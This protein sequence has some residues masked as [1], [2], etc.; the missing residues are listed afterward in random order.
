M[1]GVQTCAL[2]ICYDRDLIVTHNMTADNLLHAKKM[3]GIPVPSQIKS[4]I[5]N[6]GTFDANDPS[7]LHQ[8]DEAPKGWG[9]VEGSLE[10]RNQQPGPQSLGVISLGGFPAKPAV[11]T[12]LEKANASTYLH[13]LGHFFLETYTHIAD[14][15]NVP[16]KI[17]KDMQTILDGFGVKDVATWRAM[18]LEERRPL[19]EQ[20]AKSYEAYLMEGKAPTIAQ[21]PMFARFSAWLTKVYTSLQA[22]GVKL[23]PEVRGVMD[24]MTGSEKAIAEA[25]QVRGMEALF[26]VKPEGMTDEAYE[27]YQALGHDATGAAVASLQQRSLRDM[28]WL[29]N[30]KGRAVRSLQRQ[31]RAERVKIR[32]EVEAAVSEVP[33]YRAEDLLAKGIFNGEKVDT[34]KT[35]LDTEA[36]AEMYGGAGADGKSD[37]YALLDWKPLGKLAGPD[38]IHP[39]MAAHM[40]GFESGDALVKALLE[41]EPRKEMV[42]AMVDKR[43]LEEHGELIDP[44]SIERAAEAAIHNDMRTRVLATELTALAK[45]T[46][47]ARLLAKAAMFLAAGV[48]VDRKSVV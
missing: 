35:H 40:L 18:G 16:P 7:I 4:A 43:M 3:G 24:R 22:L 6:R 17:A 32:E 1:T 34:G 31:A 26:K 19:H 42:E 44:A 33:V 38:G 48:L 5:G 37:K 25:E 23:T 15:P 10:G 12:L 2:P 21:Q 13:E 39:D 46:G 28:Q 9:S 29:S 41:R 11:I 8:G 36:L 45:A 20:W 47:S 14:S 30:A 27:S